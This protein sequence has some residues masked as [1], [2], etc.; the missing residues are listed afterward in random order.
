ME[1]RGQFLIATPSLMDPNFNE[2]VVLILEHDDESGSFG[3]VINRPGDISVGAFCAGLG[4]EWQGDGDSAVHVGG[5]VQPMVGWLLF[6]DAELDPEIEPVLDHIVVSN[7]RETL[8]KVAARADVRRRLFTGYAGWAPG[9]LAGELRQGA[10]ITTEGDP[11]LVFTDEPK[12]AW[13]AALRSM[14]ID[15]LMLVPGSTEPT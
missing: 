5:P 13:R 1:L 6:D 10:W 8:Q 15:P 2:S 4:V 14:G 3:L 11:E 7:R 9:Q 12:R